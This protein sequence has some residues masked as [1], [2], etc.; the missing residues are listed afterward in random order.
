MFAF[1]L[2]S[3]IRLSQRLGVSCTMNVYEKVLLLVRG[4]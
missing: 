2:A 4:K 1:G 3:V